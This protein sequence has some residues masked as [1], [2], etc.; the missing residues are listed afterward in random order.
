VPFTFHSLIERRGGS[1]IRV[2][3]RSRGSD[4]TLATRAF[5]PVTLD[6]DD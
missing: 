5:D 4:A 3:A 6:E 2:L 1:G